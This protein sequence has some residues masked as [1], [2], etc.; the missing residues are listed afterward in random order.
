MRAPFSNHACLPLSHGNP[1]PC[2]HCSHLCMP[3]FHPCVPCSLVVHAFPLA[4]GASFLSCTPC[5][6][7][8]V[9]S[10]YLC[11]HP[12][13]AVRALPSPMRTYTLLYTPTPSLVQTLHPNRSCPI[14]SKYELFS[15]PRFTH[16]CPLLWSMY[17]LPS[18]VCASPPSSVYFLSSSVCAPTLASNARMESTSPLPMPYQPI[19]LTE[20]KCK[21]E[22]GHVFLFLHE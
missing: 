20:L 4:V 10:I 18:P 12:F 3:S 6:H 22:I 19:V 8:C 9:P 2:A 5:S 21:D 11:A 15:H 7:L 14:P 17:A 13:S 1:L 16:A